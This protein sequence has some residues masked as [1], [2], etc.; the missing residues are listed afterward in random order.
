MPRD[1]AIGATEDEIK[2]WGG[3]TGMTKLATVGW[4]A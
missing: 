1:G 4:N 3:A 2:F